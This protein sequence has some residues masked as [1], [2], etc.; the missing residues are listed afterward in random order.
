MAKIKFLMH[1][2]SEK[3]I[4]RDG[5]GYA[6]EKADSNGVKQRYLAGIS[7]GMAM[8]AHGDRMSKGAIQD[9]LAQTEEKDIPLYVNHGKDFTDSIGL[10]SKSEM[11]DNGDWYTEYKLYGPDDAVPSKNKEEAANVWNMANGLAPYRKSHKFGFSIEG[12][13]P[14]NQIQNDGSGRVIQ[15]VDL[16][17]GVS[18]VTQPAYT[19]SVANAIAKA[20]GKA[21]KKT[22]DEEGPERDEE[23]ET[24]FG[25]N[26][27]IEKELSPFA[28]ELQEADFASQRWKLQDAM[29]SVIY[30]IM[31]LKDKSK[32]E[33]LQL[34][35]NSMED[36][37]SAMLALFSKY[38]F[39]E[40]L[41]TEEGIEAVANSV[42]G[43]AAKALGK[44]SK[45]TNQEALTALT[46]IS[47][48]L[49]SVIDAMNQTFTVDDT[50]GDPAGQVVDGGTMQASKKKKQERLK[51]SVLDILNKIKTVRKELE[52]EEEDEPE[53]ATKDELETEPEKEN[54]DG[55]ETVEM[56]LKKLA[57]LLKKEEGAGALDPN[58]ALA[59]IEEVQ[60]GNEPEEALT[61][62]EDMAKA[63]LA[64]MS[65][66]SGTT[67]R[68][69]AA[70]GNEIRA[71][72]DKVEK[73][74][75]ALEGI[76]EGLNLP[77]LAKDFETQA[78]QQPVRKGFGPSLGRDDLGEALF[79]MIAEYVEK[80]GTSKTNGHNDKG[81]T[82]IRKN[83]GDFADY[84]IAKS[85][86]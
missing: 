82:D 40:P 73:I 19:T 48:E 64:K 76:F 4:S 81:V 36:Y 53:V 21:K 10:L 37:K 49:Q 78:P 55:E 62:F 15:K 25:M 39:E 74:G 75:K 71:L 6:I 79:G 14:D 27:S 1:P 9:F 5:T 22:K 46:E 31:E 28:E 59:P 18:L 63:L 38:D 11:L 66:R 80:S 57:G 70:S 50:S 29:S 44:L 41:A 2:A 54:D 84:F 23:S 13:I 24:D 67:T 16:D 69:S 33:K 58:D 30:E 12:F 7:S 56:M 68:K 51:K 3:K 42:L 43:R 83:A 65:K 17:P 26:N 85:R 34:L 35:E 61:E 20:L 86:R 45:T 72:S 47:A 8:D 77:T 60:P 52:T 32:E